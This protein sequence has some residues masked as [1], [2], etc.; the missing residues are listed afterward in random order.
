MKR[1]L[2]LR[3][4]SQVT[5]GKPSKLLL[6]MFDKFFHVCHQVDKAGAAW[7]CAAMNEKASTPMRDDSLYG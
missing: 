1:R 2:I 7:D 3:G 6:E 5:F 4:K